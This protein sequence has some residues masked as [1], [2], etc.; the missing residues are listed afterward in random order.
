MELD[1]KNISLQKIHEIELELMDYVHRICE[2]NNLKYYLV[3]GTLIGAIRHKGFIPWDDDMD[4]D[5]PREDYERFK[6]AVKKDPNPNYFFLNEDTKGNYYSSGKMIDTRT[7]L[8]EKEADNQAPNMGV[9]I[10]IFPID[11]LPS[12][13][14]AMI[15]HY[16]AVRLYDKL[17]MQFSHDTISKTSNPVRL[18]YRAIIWGMARIIGLERIEKKEKKLLLKYGFNHSEKVCCFFGAYGLKEVIPRSFLGERCLSEFEGHQY[19][20]PANYDA[21]LKK[22]YGDYM[23]LPPIEKRIARHD[24]EVYWKENRESSKI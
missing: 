2:E 9:Y 4:I 21:F 5:M 15:R 17:K 23:Q 24:T 10:D 22:M 7:I 3:G 18:I 16:K 8:I 11:G 13:K 20:I 19:Y 1:D 6:E 12:N 14:K